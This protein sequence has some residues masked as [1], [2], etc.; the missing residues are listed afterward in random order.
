MPSGKTHTRIDL[1]LLVIILGFAWYFWSSL[2]EFFGRDEMAEYGI[3]FV[4]AYLFGTFL[5]SP[6][7]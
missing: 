7:M 4:V 2:T 3:V 6:D 1:F 5:L